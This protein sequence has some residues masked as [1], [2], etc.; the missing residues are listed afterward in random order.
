MLCKMFI[1]KDVLKME[2]VNEF[3]CEKCAEI[4]DEVVCPYCKWDNSKWLNTINNPNK[5]TDDYLEESD[6]DN[7]GNETRSNFWISFVKIM[8]LII[9][10]ILYISALGSGITAGVLVTDILNGFVGLLAGIAVTLLSAVLSTFL[11]AISMIF[12]NMAEDISSIK[13]LLS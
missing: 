12:I 8:L 13:E 2:K 5:E 4:I 9:L 7:E 6:L 10:I 1:I 3:P 11:V